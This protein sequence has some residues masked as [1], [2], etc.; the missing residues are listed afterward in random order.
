MLRKA[1]TFAACDLRRCP[2][3]QLAETGSGL[4]LVAGHENMS[5]THRSLHPNRTAAERAMTAAGPT[6][7]A[8][9]KQNPTS[10]S[11]RLA[12]LP[13]PLAGNRLCEGE[14]SN[15]HGSYPTGT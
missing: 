8:P 5:S 2:L 9:P 13:N 14:D 11:Q 4:G 3:T 6:G 1:A 10:A 12:G 15:L 7:F